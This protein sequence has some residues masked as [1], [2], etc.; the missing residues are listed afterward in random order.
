MKTLTVGVCFLDDEN[1]VI[2]KRTIG[3]NWT[4][5]MEEDF[6][7]EFNGYLMDEVATILTENV[8][9]QLTEEVMKDMLAELHK[10]NAECVE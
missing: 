3:T 8:K 4:L 2:V 6:K 1:N 5:D 7:K 9:L 10:R